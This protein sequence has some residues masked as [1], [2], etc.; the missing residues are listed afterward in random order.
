MCRASSGISSVIGNVSYIVRDFIVG[1][2]PTNFFK[3]VHID[4]SMSALEYDKSEYFKTEKPILIIRPRFSLDD[5]TVFGRL[6]DWMSTNYFLFKQLQG[7]YSPVF[8]DLEKETYIYSVPDRVKITFEIEIIAS[9]R[10]QQINIAHFWKGAVL[11]R[12]YFYLKNSYIETEVPKYF[13]KTLSSLMDYNMQIPQQ[14]DEFLS[15]LDKGS[16]SF[17]TEKVRASSGNPSYFYIYSTNMLCQFEDV[18]QFDDGEQNNQTYENFRVTNTFTVEFWTPSNFFLETNTVVPPEIKDP[19]PDDLSIDLLGDH[20]VMNFTFGGSKPAEKLDNGM[21]YFRKQGYITDSNTE[22]DE[23]P[24]DDFL[25]EDIKDVIA[26]N[27]KYGIDN[28]EIFNIRLFRE[29]KEVDPADVNILWDKLTLQNF[30]PSPDT[31]YFIFLYAD[32]ERV[33]RTVYRLHEIRKEVYHD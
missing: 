33:V 17:I 28:D 13:I 24:L 19:S 20:V 23:L 21:V 7:N 18:P 26:Y 4:T 15:Y 25:A 29:N 8:V 27:L 2:F 12:G 31:T 9:T 22:L 30:N 32:K 6:P 16:Q 3:K 14:K 10:M 11:H 5:N 1:L